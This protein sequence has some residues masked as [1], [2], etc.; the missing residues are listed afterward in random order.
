MK[1]FSGF[2]EGYSPYKLLNVCGNRLLN[3]TILMSAWGELP[4]L[5][6]QGNKP[7][8]WM[9]AI[10]SPGDK[11]LVS[12]VEASISQH[13]LVRVEQADKQLV[14]KIQGATVLRIEQ[15]GPDQA[16][17]SELDLRPL[18]FNVYGNVGQLNAGGM[19]MIGSTFSGGT[20]VNFAGP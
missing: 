8:I 18:G 10:Q 14:V 19:I 2:P 11:R 17:I 4:F 5:I 3:G 6:G 16:L 13:Q 7:Q 20:V 1:N 12:I 9:R 15:T